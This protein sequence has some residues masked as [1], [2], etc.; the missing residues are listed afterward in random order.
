M[1][2][3]SKFSKFMHQVVA[4]LDLC[5]VY[6]DYILIASKNTQNYLPDLEQVLK[7]FKKIK[8]INVSKCTFGQTEVKFQKK[9]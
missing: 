5:F 6:L 3:N 1:Q 4:G 9:A 2:R 7:R 8:S